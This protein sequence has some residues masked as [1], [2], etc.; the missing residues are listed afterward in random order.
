MKSKKKAKCKST[1][2]T[3]FEIKKKCRGYVKQKETKRKEKREKN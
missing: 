3:Y 2:S 1:Y